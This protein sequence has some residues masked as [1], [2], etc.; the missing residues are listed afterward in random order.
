MKTIKKAIVFI[1]EWV[2]EC[3]R[4]QLTERR[5]RKVVLK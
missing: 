2:I 5:Y 3:E 1:I 4:Y